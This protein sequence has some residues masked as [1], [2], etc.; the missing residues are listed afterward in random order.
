[1]SEEQLI[2]DLPHRAALAAEDFLVSD[3]NRAA[4]RLI[5]SWPDWPDRVQLLIGPEA[6]GKTHLVR[7]WQAMSGAEM[8]A[9]DRLDMRGLDAL[10]EGSAIS[11]EDIDREGYDEKALFHLLNAARE[12]QLFLLMTSRE[13]PS[14]ID[15]TLP[16]L[17][18]RLSALPAVSIGVPDDALL[19]TVMLKQFADRQ[20]S[21]EPKVLDFLAL[22]I[23]RSLAAASLAVQAV[24]RAALASGRK[25]TRQLAASVLSGAELEDERG[26]G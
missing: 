14:R 7:V 22:H 24:D 9:P 13:A 26:A 3:C 17:R 25:I 10:G 18:S 1:V 5:D 6:S 15:Y 11:V 4:V 20:L 21:I 12:K 23:D 16:D 8:L 2:L 19:K